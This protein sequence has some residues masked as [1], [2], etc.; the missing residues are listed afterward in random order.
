[1]NSRLTYI[2]QEV[3]RQTSSL[4]VLVGFI[5]RQKEKLI[6]RMRRVSLIP[7]MEM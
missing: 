6:L 1:M 4:L 5:D 7:L 2:S 3:V